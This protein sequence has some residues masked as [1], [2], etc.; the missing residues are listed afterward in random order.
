MGTRARIVRI[1]NSRG[2]RL[3]RA[4]LEQCQ[5]GDTVDLSVEAGVLVV[6]PIRSPRAGWDEAFQ[7]MA[8]AG[9]DVLLDAES[10][11]GTAWDQVEW[12]WPEA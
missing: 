10:P 9:D 8:Q 12:E 3:P 7:E 1:G 6:R 4:V 2:I 11:T 5:L